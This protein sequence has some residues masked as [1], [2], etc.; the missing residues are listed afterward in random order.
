MKQDSVLEHGSI[1]VTKGTSIESRD[2]SLENA[3]VR[4]IEFIGATLLVTRSRSC[5]FQ[6]TKAMVS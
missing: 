3:A 2:I 1:S 5:E 4:N 6:L